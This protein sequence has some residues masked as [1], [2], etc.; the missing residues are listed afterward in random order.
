VHA[1]AAFPAPT[2]PFSNRPPIALLPLRELPP[3]GPA[4]SLGGEGGG[5]NPVLLKR[6]QKIIIYWTDTPLQS[7]C[8][9]TSDGG[10]CCEG[11]DALPQKFLGEG[12]TDRMRWVSDPGN[13]SI[14]RENIT[15]FGVFRFLPTSSPVTPDTPPSLTTA[16]SKVCLR[17]C[18]RLLR[19]TFPSI[20]IQNHD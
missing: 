6:S 1:C 15:L 4:H 17:G 10:K 16:G 2:P 12:S 8:P 19:P 20:S 7:D 5:S 14:L 9:P 18:S 3:A 11:R 13:H